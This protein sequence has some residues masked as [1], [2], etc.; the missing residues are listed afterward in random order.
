MLVGLFTQAIGNGLFIL[1]LPL[2][3]NRIG[4]LSIS[5][6][7]RIILGAGQ[8]L[9]MTP[10]YSIISILYKHNLEHYIG[11]CEVMCGFGLS[12]GPMIGG[13]LAEIGGFHLPFI[14]NVACTLANIPIVWRVIPTNLED[15]RYD[16][17]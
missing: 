7:A 10:A 8:A 3:H 6:V 17:D 1:V 13:V 16:S 9:F 11:L 4:Y 14:F 5:I 15:Y 2:E 12:I